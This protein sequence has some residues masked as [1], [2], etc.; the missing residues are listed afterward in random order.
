MAAREILVDGDSILQLL[1]HYTDGEIPL[2]AEMRGC[3]VSTRLQMLINFDVGSEEWPQELI[4]SPLHVRYEG[5]K[6]MCWGDDKM[7]P[8]VW[9]EAQE[10]P[11]K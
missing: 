1:V 3:Q 10:G 11:K 5:N 2:D 4:G 7:V 9:V 8:P 6:V